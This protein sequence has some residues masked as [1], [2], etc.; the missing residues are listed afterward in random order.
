MTQLLFTKCNYWGLQQDQAKSRAAFTAGNNFYTD[1]K[2]VLLPQQL[3]R[4]TP[5]S[6]MSTFT[7]LQTP[8][9]TAVPLEPAAASGSAVGG[10]GGSGGLMSR[11]VTALPTVET[12]KNK[13]GDVWGRARSWSDFF[14]T[15]QMNKPAPAEMMERIKENL[16]HYA[17]NYLVIL[18]VLSA[19]TILTSPF[20][21]LG[22][23][24]VAAAYA[25]LFLLNPEPIMIAGL[26]VDNNAKA[27]IITFASLAVLW[28]TGAGAAFTSLI[29]VVGI[30]ALGHAA[31][32]KPPGEA[33]FETA[34][35]P[36]TV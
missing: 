14:N 11:L 26:P 19:F 33:D 12:V 9:E 1:L 10:E 6:T 30:I 5:S 17:F 13:L 28:L 18:L 15:A 31:V 34:Y 29:V 3:T 21:F 27:A 36:A 2:T 7:E 32:R 22:G 16:E 4:L 25:Y 23:L 24:F 35:T 20:T 8:A